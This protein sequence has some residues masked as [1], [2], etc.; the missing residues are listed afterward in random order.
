M[1]YSV[2]DNGVG[3]D[4]AYANKLFGVFER[5]HHPDEVEGAGVG[6]ALVSR[7]VGRHGGRIWGEGAV[8]HGATFWF[9][10]PAMEGDGQ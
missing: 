6:L 4:M 3:F 5:L 9:T 1:V 2:S 8:D 7:I 10:L